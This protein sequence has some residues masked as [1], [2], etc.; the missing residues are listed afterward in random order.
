M[1]DEQ[2]VFTGTVNQF[3]TNAAQRR[4]QLES[5]YAPVTGVQSVDGNTESATTGEPMS[6][7]INP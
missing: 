7:D 5:M 1:A 2:N 6:N 4:K 3:T